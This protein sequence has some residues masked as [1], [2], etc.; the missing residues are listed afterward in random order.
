VASSWYKDDA[1]RITNNWGS[2]T[3]R[4]WWLTRRSP[5]YSY[6]RTPRSDKVARS[7]SVNHSDG[8]FASGRN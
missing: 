5:S 8:S 7:V 4:Y 6:V 1:G 3:P 2:G